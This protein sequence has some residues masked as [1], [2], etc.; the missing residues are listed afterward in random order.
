MPVYKVLYK[1]VIFMY[2]E[3]EGAY[4]FADVTF[5]VSLLAERKV[6]NIVSKWYVEH[7]PTILK[8]GRDICHVRVADAKGQGHSDLEHDFS[9]WSIFLKHMDPQS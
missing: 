8:L 5:S 7:K 1:A 4:R 2:P 9:F 6:D 3:A